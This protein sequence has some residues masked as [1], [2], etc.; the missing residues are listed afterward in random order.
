MYASEMVFPFILKSQLIQHSRKIPLQKLRTTIP[1]LKILLA[2]YILAMWAL[3]IITNP[4]L[5]N[6]NKVLIYII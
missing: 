2:Q 6:N 4:T 5:L 3:R 1:L